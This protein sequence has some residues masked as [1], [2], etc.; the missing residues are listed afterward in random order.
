MVNAQ[1]MNQDMIDQPTSQGQLVVLGAGVIGLQT[2]ICLLEA[3]FQVTILAKYWPGD[4]ERLYTSMWAGAQWRSSSTMH[5]IKMQEWQKLTF[6]H[7]QN[8]VRVV[9]V[10]KTG[11]EMKPA[12]YFW[13]YTTP[14]EIPPEQWIWWTSLVSSYQV[15]AQSA[16]PATGSHAAGISYDSFA[17]NPAKYLSYLSSRS[18]EL[19][20]K[21]ITSEVQSFTEIF[22]K[23]ENVRGV[24]NCT[25][26]GA[27]KLVEDPKLFPTKGQSV[28]VRGLAHGITTGLGDDWETVIVPRYGTNETF[29]GVSKV[30]GD[31][32]LDADESVTQA[33][34]QR[35]KLFAPELLNDNGEF[36]V[37]SVQVGLRP[38]RTGGPRVEIQKYRDN[39]E[40]TNKFVC[41][42]YGHH[43]AGFEES[44]GTGKTVTDLV[45]AELT[46]ESKN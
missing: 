18:K 20:A 45:K 38:T 39:N 15:L 29:L 22:H 17:V 28:I 8:L 12:T 24:I 21:H 34:L 40:A 7:W 42:N 25:G 37:L 10:E 5:E 11:L 30:P 3:G 26:L 14:L 4:Q 19:G 32:S 31:W 44:F 27:T 9:S 36:E 6:K 1:R 16:I 43:G 23:F 13:D 46:D 2:A 35:C 33:I 41:H